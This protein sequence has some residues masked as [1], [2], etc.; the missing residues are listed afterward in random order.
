MAV[1]HA[2]LS[3]PCRSHHQQAA[4]AGDPF[5]RFIGGKVPVWDIRENFGDTNL[6]VTNMAQGR[7]LAK[8]LGG[9]LSR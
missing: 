9:G 5:R 6:L 7:D 8:S 3:T 2:T 1:V 4:P